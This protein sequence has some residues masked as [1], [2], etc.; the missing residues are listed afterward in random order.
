MGS[1]CYNLRVGQRCYSAVGLV[2]MFLRDFVWSDT[3]GVETE[4]WSFGV[5]EVTMAHV[6]R[7]FIELR[8]LIFPTYA[9]QVPKLPASF[10]GLMGLGLVGNPKPSTRAQAAVQSSG[11]APETHSSQ[12]QQLRVC[13]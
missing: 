7:S 11:F 5:V 2:L 9:W 13:L 8:A 12:T 4:V 3:V 10:F 1:G 6:F